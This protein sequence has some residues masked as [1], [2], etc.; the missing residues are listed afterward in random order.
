RGGEVV[1]GVPIHGFSGPCVFNLERSNT[2]SEGGASDRSAQDFL[3]KLARIVE[4]N[5]SI[6]TFAQADAAV[7]LPAQRSEGPSGSTSFVLTGPALS[8]PT[9]TRVTRRGYFVA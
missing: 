6:S 2:T 7:C 5:A 4:R 3:F 8:M 1:A 9:V